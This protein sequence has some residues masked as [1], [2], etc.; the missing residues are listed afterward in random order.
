M[1][2]IAAAALI[3]G[4]GAG[5]ATA[6]PI[7]VTGHD[8]DIV[9]EAGN[10]AI[11]TVTTAGVLLDIFTLAEVGY[12]GSG[13]QN[14]TPL[15]ITGDTVTTKNGTVFNVDPGANNAING[16][17]DA[18][19][20]TFTLTAPGS[21]E[22]LQFLYFGASGGLTATLN[23]ADASSTEYEVIA[24]VTDWQATSANN[25]FDSKSASARRDNGNYLPLWLREF[26]LTL[27]AGDQ[28]KTINSIDI[29][30]GNR[31]SVLAVS[32][33]VVP[34]PGSLALLG[35]GGLLIARRRRG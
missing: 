31:A 9:A 23:F 10:G 15:T 20:G 30:I 33:T 2:R 7:A 34:E 28:L 5:T 6:A 25:A 8:S 29:A 14:G 26:D 12:T 1:K 24:S 11:G 22:S 16:S 21:Y 13:T 18:L 17:D 19:D 35:L 32:G 27:S 3:A 4:L